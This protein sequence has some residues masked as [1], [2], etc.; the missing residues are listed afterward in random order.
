MCSVDG[1]EPFELLA[2]AERLESVGR[3]AGAVLVWLRARGELEDVRTQLAVQFGK[4][5]GS[6]VQSGVIK[7]ELMPGSPTVPA[8]GQP[9]N[10]LWVR[11]G[12]HDVG[13]SADL[14]REWSSRLT[15]DGDVALQA[16]S[17]G[18]LDGYFKEGRRSMELTESGERMAE[19]LS[20]WFGPLFG[21]EYLREVEDEIAAIRYGETSQARVV[22][23]F[24]KSLRPLLEDLSARVR[25][26]ADSR[27]HTEGTGERCPRCGKPLVRMARRSGLVTTCMDYPVCAFSRGSGKA[28]RAKQ[29]SA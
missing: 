11:T 7:A 20:A 5:P 23:N 10:Q 26:V 15:G 3:I 28:L 19:C 16:V 1:F 9:L 22:G 13:R 29:M 17:R 18:L 2:G 25:D 14:C 6:P 21:L 24:W 27:K 4:V 8:V 12:F